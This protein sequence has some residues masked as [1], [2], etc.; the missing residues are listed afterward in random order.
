[1]GHVLDEGVWVKKKNYKPKVNPASAEGSSSIRLDGA[2]GVVL[3][4]LLSE[5]Q[6]I[7][8]SLGAVIGDLHKCTEFLAKLSTN[9]TSLQA[10][11]SLIQREGMKSFNL[12]LKQVDSVAAPAELSDNE[13]AVAVQNSYSSE[14]NRLIDST[15]RPVKL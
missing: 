10:Q 6:D 1:M 4:S 9:V 2:Q 12:V 14:L 3:N 5:P 8:Q 11:L 7:K 15:N 13:L